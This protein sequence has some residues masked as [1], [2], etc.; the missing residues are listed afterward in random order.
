MRQ[1]L[2]VAY[3]FPPLGGIGSLRVTGYATHLPEYGWSPTVLAPR[4]GAYYRDPGLSF[5]EARVVRTASIELSRAGK[6]V[7]RAGGDD[8]T[9]AAVGGLRASLRG[10][11]RSALYFPDPQVGWYAPAVLSARRALRG[12]RFDAV[13]SSSFPITAHLVARTLHRRLGVPWVAEFRDP[14]SAMLAADD[15]IRGRALRLERSLAREADAVVM[16]SPS[17]ATRHAAD[18]GR[19]VSVIPNGHDGQ[20]APVGSPDGSITLAY[21][22]SY[23]PATQRLDAVWPAI[24]RINARG[25][26]TVDRIRFIGD[27]HPALAAELRSQ[28]LDGLVEVTGFLP[29]DEALRSLQ[30]ASALLVAGPRD[31]GGILRGQVAAKLSEYLAS[32]L[33]IVY[34]GDPACDAA[35]LLRRYSGTSV[36]ATEDDAGVERALLAC[37]GRRIVRDVGDL[38]RRALA[39]DLAR[40]LDAA[41]QKA[42]DRWRR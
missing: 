33:P 26:L 24:R 8:T 20:M 39:G 5:D 35:D 9:P 1:A 28:G 11:A 25:E 37:L 40:V 36:V 22:G 21:L 30:T 14:W 4:N 2:I 23:Y 32:G 15:P 19:E 18:W 10:L 16:T 6:R 17:W 12:R 3:Y 31:A 29:H 41:A 38:S 27:L 34:V 7:L 13:F 42:G